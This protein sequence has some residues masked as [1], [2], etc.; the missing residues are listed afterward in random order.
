MSTETIHILLADIVSMC[1]LIRLRRLK[2]SINELGHA[3]RQN[4][5]HVI[6]QFPLSKC[7]IRTPPPSATEFVA[8][9]IEEVIEIV[10]V[11]H[12]NPLPRVFAIE[13]LQMLGNL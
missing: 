4:G 6:P 5:I 9:A 8:E 11:D 3:Q 10:V 13:H 7:A 2:D 12:E 1:G